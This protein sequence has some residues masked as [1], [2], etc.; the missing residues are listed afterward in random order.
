ML[1]TSMF[2]VRETRQVVIPSML[3]ISV[4]ITRFRIFFQADPL[5]LEPNPTPAPVWTQNW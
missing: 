3:V 4:A 2:S 1:I 5:H